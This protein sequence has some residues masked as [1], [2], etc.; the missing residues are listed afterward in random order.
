MDKLRV[1]VQVGHESPRQPG[2]EDN[3]GSAGEVEMVREIG[4]ALMNQLRAD[5]RFRPRLIPG[6]VP[7]EVEDGSFPVDAFIALHCDGAENK[8]AEGYSVG[9]PPDPVNKRLAH[10]IADEFATFHR[11]DRRADNNTPGMSN[12]YAYKRVPTSG[13]ECLIEHGF[14][15]NPTERQWM[16]EHVKQLAAAEYRGL[17]AFFD[18]DELDAGPSDP[19]APRGLLNPQPIAFTEDSPLIGPPSATR[20]QLRV[21]LLSRPHGVYSDRR[22]R[23]IA[24]LYVETATS[25]GLD[26]LVAVAQMVLETGNLTSFWSQPPR[27]NPAGIGVTGEPGVGLSFVSWRQAVR[28]HVGRLVAYALPPGTENAGQA[29]LVDMALDVRPLPADQRGV[30]PTLAGLAGTWAADQAY[31]DKLSRVAHGIL[32]G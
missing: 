22:V 20:H 17:L 25:V 6:R 10:L 15:S 30:A 31:A 21:A 18:L 7:A 9:F 5:R 16:K 24:N 28:A 2:F 1:L 23:K 3:T 27:R 14:V 29:A 8:A 13:P 4:A 19:D 32:E 26:P 11:S 12:Y